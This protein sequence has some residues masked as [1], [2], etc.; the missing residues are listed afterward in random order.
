MFS[1]SL[2]T[3]SCAA[4]LWSSGVMAQTSLFTTQLPKIAGEQDG[5]NYELGMRFMSSSAGKITA[6]RFYKSAKESGQ[7][8]GKIYSSRG[9]LLA[10]VVFANESASGWQQQALAA[11]LA[12]SANVEYTVSVNTGGMYY[13]DTIN[14]FASQISN[15]ALKSASGRNGVYGPVGSR[16]TSSWQQSNYFRDVVFV[17]NSAPVPPV[18]VVPP[19]VITPPVVTPPAPVPVPPVSVTGWPNA[20]NTGVPAGTV[21]TAYTG[22]CRIT[23]PNTVIDAKQVNCTLTIATTGV[24]ITRSKI[25]GSVYSADGTPTTGPRSVIL[26][27]TEID[28]GTDLNAGGLDAINFEAYRM[29]IHGGHRGVWC[30]T[31]I[32]QDSYIHM[33]TRA[34]DGKAHQS[35]VRMEQNGKIIHNTLLCDAPDIGDDGG[36][37]APLTGYGD[38]ST[39]QNNLIQGNLLK[40][41]TGGTCAYGGSSGLGSGAKPFPNANNIVFKDNVFERGNGPSD[42]GNFGLCGYYFPVTDF[43]VSAPGN[44]WSNNKWDDGGILMP[45]ASM[46]NPPAKK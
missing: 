10:S 17:S 44:S 25:N 46:F 39:V 37:S 5:V 40:A 6:I 34:V 29:N 11:P 12:I 13:V 41:T 43:N 38:F 20:S 32:L 31:C 4:L 24:K 9:A 8:I 14:G 33:S 7:H 21:L 1:K 23:V 45:D 27:D 22:P 35:A 15:G 2:F 42:K 36:C 18:V 16:P 3:L 26:S 28:A 30:M 19:P